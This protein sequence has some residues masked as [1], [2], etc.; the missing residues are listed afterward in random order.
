M[1]PL[2]NRL[3]E[4][5]EE[6]TRGGFSLFLGN[7]SATFIS[8]L[9]AM[10]VARLL[11][12]AKYGL[13]ALSLVIPYLAVAIIDLGLSPALTRYSAKLRS[14]G[15]GSEVEIM[16]RSVFIFKV[17]LAALALIFVVLLSEPLAA[18]GLSRPGM[19]EYVRLASLLIAFQAIATAASAALIGLD[20]M[21]DASIIMTAQSASRGLVSPIL[22]LIGM[23][24]TGA[25]LGN[26]IGFAVGA[27][28]GLLA[29][30][31][32][33]QSLSMNSK[34]SAMGYVESLRVAARYGLPLYLTALL[35][36]VLV[37]Y[38]NLVLAHN[39]SDVEI[40]NFNAAVNFS[41]VVNL[42]AFPIATVLFPAFSKINPYSENDDLKRMFQMSVR[43]GSL[44][45]IPASMIVAVLSK[46]LVFT[47]YGGSFGTAPLYLSIY[48]TI[49]LLICLGY[50]ILV[51]LFNGIGETGE[52]LK[53]T[54]VTAALFLPMAPVMAQAYHVVGL[55]VALLAS[56][57]A[58]AAYGLYKA[59]MK[60]HLNLDLNSSL[61]IYLASAISILPTLLLLSAVN[62][63][64]LLNIAIGGFTYLA[65]YL[66][67][68][69]LI[70]AV[71]RSDIDNL[72]QILSKIKIVNPIVKPI[73][74]YENR[75]LTALE[76]ATA[77]RLQE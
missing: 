29:L 26:V 35:T 75:I 56:N 46:D 76:S 62:L 69:P 21:R 48:I 11:G 61:R 2:S 7:A 55:I 70:G 44:L 51:S 10:I 50:L 19:A 53:I 58:G 40:G 63:P 32:M 38:Q 74:I 12:P 64:S 5:A 9:A 68:A 67:F 36:M 66:T 42:V 60:F 28:L 72:S 17:L 25:I 14:E 52:T 23:S 34:S 20:K 3:V 45:L 13:Y 54:V 39:V 18:T 59:R 6:S 41:A 8:A 31:I 1:Q 47:I 71:K 24:V 4:F 33:R 15:R 43:Y 22:V 30:F 57:L 73:I 77:K 27:G 16:L 49:F 37:Q 65:S